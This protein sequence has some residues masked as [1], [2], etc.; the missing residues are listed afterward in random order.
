MSE[1]STVHIATVTNTFEDLIVGH[2]VTIITTTQT[3]ILVENTSNNLP[4]TITVFPSST[5]SIPTITRPTTVVTI[6]RE[7]V[8]TYMTNS[9]I[10][11][12]TRRRK[13]TKFYGDLVENL[14]DDCI[15]I[16]DFVII[17]PR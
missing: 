4:K 15:Y 14:D 9:G 17:T 3:Q 1:N 13:K 8:N 11:P 6:P 5:L 16:D 10:L 12:A 2:K 7:A